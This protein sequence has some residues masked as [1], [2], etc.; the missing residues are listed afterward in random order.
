[1]TNLGQRVRVRVVPSGGAVEAPRSYLKV[2]VRNDWSGRCRGCGDPYPP[3]PTGVPPGVGGDK[4]GSGSG[5][6]GPD[7][8]RL[9][10]AGDLRWRAGDRNRVVDGRVVGVVIAQ[11]QNRPQ[12]QS[13]C[14]N[15]GIEIVLTDIGYVHIDIQGQ[16]T[17][18]LCPRP[19]MTLATRADEADQ[20]LARVVPHQQ[21]P[22][23]TSRSPDAQSSPLPH[24]KLPST[25]PRVRAT[26]AV[27]GRPHEALRVAP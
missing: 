20:I 10:G 7:D 17:G 18:W 27:S 23:E 26:Q 13:N 3:H 2:H 15:C 19:N 5:T 22:S 14:A 16:H 21:A 4:A 6:G 11:D 8:L 9:G 1:M 12:D 24:R 25:W